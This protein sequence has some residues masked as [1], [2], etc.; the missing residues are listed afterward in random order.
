M[1]P[2]KTEPNPLI[3]AESLSFTSA[4]HLCYIVADTAIR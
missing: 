1:R 3:C 4:M 2:A